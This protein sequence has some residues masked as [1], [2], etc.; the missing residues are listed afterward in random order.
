MKRY[1]SVGDLA[2]S[3]LRSGHGDEAR[4][5]MGE[6]EDVAARTPSPRIHVAMCHA[7]PLIADE[8]AEALFAAALRADTPRWLF[9]RARLHL[10]HGTW[11]RRERRIGESRAPLRTA[12]DT[13]DALGLIP[14]G[15]RAWQELQI[16][17]MAAEGLSNREIGQ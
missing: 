3:A 12:R 13:F 1:W 5:L 8:D 7:R 6:L 4:A 11:L 2:E 16:A 9:S 15:E 14:W 17:R 10:A